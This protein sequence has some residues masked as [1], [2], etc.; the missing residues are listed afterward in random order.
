MVQSPSGMKAFAIRAIR[1]VLLGILLGAATVLCARLLHAA[2]NWILPTFPA[3]FTKISL[4]WTMVAA[5]AAPALLLGAE[6]LAS[7]AARVYCS[8]TAGIV[9]GVIPVWFLVSLSFFLLLA[10]RNRLYIAT[11]ERIRYFV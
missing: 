7:L 6:K 2:T 10:C 4:F 5:I 3:A 1:G 8:W 9:T 11:N